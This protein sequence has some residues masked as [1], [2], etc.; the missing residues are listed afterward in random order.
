MT[1]ED[2]LST[3]RLLWRLSQTGS[4]SRAA[5][6]EN[7]DLSSA[8]RQLRDLEEALG[9]KLLQ[10]NRRP[11]ALRPEVVSV[12]ES[13]HDTLQAL[14]LVRETLVNMASERESMTIRFGLPTNIARDRMVRFL[15]G[16][17]LSSAGINVVLTDAS[18]HH[19]VLDNRVD[20]AYCPYHPH[21]AA[22]NDL[23]IVP[24][25][26]ATTLL[27]ATPQYL[28]EHG[29]PLS[30]TDLYQHRLILRKD[31]HYPITER[32][33]S[34][35][36]EFHFRAGRVVTH[37]PDGTQ[38]EAYVAPVTETFEA[39]T[40][41]CLQATFDGHGIAVDLSI[42]FVVR[43]IESGQLV[44]VMPGWHRPL[45]ELTL[46]THEALWLHPVVGNFLKAYVKAEVASQTQWQMILKRYGVNV[47]ALLNRSRA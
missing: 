2:N 4:L 36:G 12:V 20:V 22:L 21:V 5:Q 29:T 33:I 1:P 32:L 16:Y 44:P 9:G 31:A 3:W 45:W 41:S 35:T 10:R 6:E 37:H 27:L 43:L 42:G 24:L 28:A 13:L 34:E 26:K 19:D 47:E 7:M 18:S 11:L 8:S 15:S 46:V 25:F 17:P 30:P 40:L 38:T 14:S 23:T 39:D